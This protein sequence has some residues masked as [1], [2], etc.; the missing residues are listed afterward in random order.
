MNWVHETLADFGKR[1][2]LTNFGTSAH[3][4]AQLRMASGALLAVE[5][6]QRGEI[7]E[8]LVYLGQPVGFEAAHLSR[9]ALEKVH[10]SNGGSFPL[11]I[12]TRGEGAERMLLMLTRIPEREFTP[13]ILEQAVD[14]L[15]RWYDELKNGR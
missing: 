3:D 8:V 4:V 2:G 15:N 1:L 10:F 13:Q 12:A 14:Y 6:V 11:Q 5:P 7:D 9:Q